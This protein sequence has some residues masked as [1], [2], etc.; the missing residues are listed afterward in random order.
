MT[1]LASTTVRTAS[2]EQAS[3]RSSSTKKVWRDRQQQQQQEEEEEE[4]QQQRQGVEKEE[5]VS[6]SSSSSSPREVRLHLHAYPLSCDLLS[7][8]FPPSGR[9]LHIQPQVRTCH[10]ICL[11]QS[12]RNIT[13][14][15]LMTHPDDT[16]T[17][18][19]P[20]PEV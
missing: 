16:T 9:L 19:L 2:R 10:S 11:P 1:C 20:S 13:H 17:H 3:L 18:H 5:R 7:N 4:G 15:P 14:C 8:C 6:G 12:P